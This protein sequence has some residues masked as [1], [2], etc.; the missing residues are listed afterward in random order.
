[1]LPV[2]RG[3][4]TV[5]DEWI[6]HGSGGNPSDRVRKTYV[7]AYRDASMVDY[8]R[9]I[10]FSHSYNNDPEVIRRIRAREL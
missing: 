2:K 9:A 1:M 6:V 10:G 8:E 4:V 3:D 5:H 7:A